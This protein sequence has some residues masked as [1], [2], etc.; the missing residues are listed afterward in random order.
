MLPNYERAKL[1]R[2]LTLP[3]VVQSCLGAFWKSLLHVLG[4]SA[5]DSGLA[6]YIL[7][8]VVFVT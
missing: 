2:C 4:L 8:L 1:F 5:K 7:R 3:T 6:V